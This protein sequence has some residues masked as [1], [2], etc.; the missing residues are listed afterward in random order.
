MILI[1]AILVVGF[2]IFLFRVL[3]NPASY[4]LKAWIKVLVALFVVLAIAAVIVPGVTNEIAEF[5]GVTRGADL[6]LYML[7]MAFIFT[8]MNGYI[9]S[10]KTQEK[11][12]TLARRIAINEANLRDF[13]KQSSK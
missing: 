4:K 9:Q 8:I 10:K 12:T 1:Q 6:L 3:A 13:D 2:G 5:V 7:T 11:I